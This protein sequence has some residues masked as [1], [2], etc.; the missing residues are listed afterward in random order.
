MSA[1]STLSS[2]RNL[3]KSKFGIAGG[4]ILATVGLQVG[5][6]QYYKPWNRRR[7]LKAAEEIG[8]IL[9]RQEME[10]DRHLYSK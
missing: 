6:H 4:V 1:D 3:L 5:Y 10:R 9:F 7:E 2:F 8:E